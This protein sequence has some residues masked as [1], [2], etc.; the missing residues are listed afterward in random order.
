MKMKKNKFK[1]RKKWENEKDAK[2][3]YKKQEV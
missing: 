1:L 3:T 2:K